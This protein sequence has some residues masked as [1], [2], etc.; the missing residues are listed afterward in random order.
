MKK[1]TI[2]NLSAKKITAM[3]L[4]AVI[5]LSF[6]IPAA[7]YAVTQSDLDQANARLEQLRKEQAALSSEYARLNES[8]QIAMN[9]LAAID[10]Q[11]SAKQTDIDKLQVELKDLNQDIDDQ[12]EAMKLRIQYMY[13]AQSSNLWNLILS[14]KNFSDM[15]MHAEYVAQLS[16]YDRSKL[17]EF[18]TSLAQKQQVAERLQSDMQTLNG[19]RNS[20]AAKADNI[21]NLLAQKQKEINASSTSIKQVE[22][23]AIAYEK[24]IEEERIA[25]QEAERNQL[26]GGSLD[27][28]VSSDT[29]PISY[30]AK[31]LAMLAAI[32]ECEAGN[33]PYEGLIAVGSVVINRIRDPRFANTL[34]GVLFSPGQFTPVAS[35]RFAIVLARGAT[36]RCVEAAKEVLNGKINIKALYFHRYRPE[37][38]ETGTIIGDHIFM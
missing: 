29:A 19:L 30:D 15:L 17:T 7:T 21:K 22:E 14:S 28:A 8:L 3:V 38:N 37:K 20:A 4:S 16:A 32:I 2:L 13:E 25:Q 33:Q 24:A 10:V 11:I 18:E 35:G 34:S 31:D 5:C 26:S 9:E 27:S 12:Y 36:E 1:S 23:L 6:T